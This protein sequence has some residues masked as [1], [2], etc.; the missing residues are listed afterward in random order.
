MRVDFRSY[1]AYDVNGGSHRVTI[2]AAKNVE[3]QMRQEQIAQATLEEIVANGLAK[4]SVAAVARRVGV[5][6][7]ALYRHFKSKDEVLD[8]TME[9]ILGRL[10]KNV[11]AVLA[12]SGTPL[13]HLKQLLDRHV[14]MIRANRGAPQMLLSQDFYAQRPDRRRRVYEGIQ[15][16]LA[17]VAEVICEAQRCGQVDP[18][19]D[20]QAVSV[21]FLG[22]IQPPAILWH[23]SNGAFDV[24]RQTS[25]A[26]T[27]FLKAIG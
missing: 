23:M 14:G 17:R 25:H 19:I 5:V 9:M 16:Y 20:A 21:M 15:A 8:A 6:P 24:D 4:V 7:S 11:D 12:E 13:G 1:G 27:L 2:M 10:L 22:L 26:W 18:Q 3:T